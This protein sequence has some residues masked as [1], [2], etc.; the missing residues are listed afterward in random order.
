MATPSGRGWDDLEAGSSEV[1][2]V[3]VVREPGNQM[4][5][6]RSKVSHDRSKPENRQYP[7]QACAFL[8]LKSFPTRSAQRAG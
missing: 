7:Y 8:H 5:L 4:T 2:A 3:E 1:G 6:I